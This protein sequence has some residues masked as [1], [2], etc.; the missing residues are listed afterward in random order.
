ML[1]LGVEFVKC[2]IQKVTSPEQRVI[3]R[4]STEL[5][6]KKKT[7]YELERMIGFLVNKGFSPKEIAKQT[8]VTTYTINRHIRSLDV[9]K[10]LKKRAELAKVGKDG[11]TRLCKLPNVTNEIKS[12]LIEDYLQKVFFGYQVDSIEQVVMDSHF[13]QLSNE[14]KQCSIKQAID[15]SKFAQPQAK[16]I[17]YS[18]IV[19]EQQ[20]CD[21]EVINFVYRNTCT[22][23]VDIIGICNSTFQDQL[24]RLQI[25]NLQLLIHSLV[26]VT[27]TPY[28]WSNFPNETIGNRND[29]QTDSD[30]LN[31]N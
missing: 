27:K 23:L 14:G 28:Y 22:Q 29:Q 12:D 9:D 21:E 6:R 30:Y 1:S 10:E 20:I 3:K 2:I 19:K 11:L 26:Q 18:N 16:K 7:G 13:V 25:R 31:R 4:L 15:E 24:S 5:H 8:D 17:I